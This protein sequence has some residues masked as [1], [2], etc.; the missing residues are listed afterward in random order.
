MADFEQ[1][2]KEIVDYLAPRQTVYEHAIYH[3]LFRRSH[4]EGSGEVRVGQRSLLRMLPRPSKEG[5]SNRGG[6]V[7]GGSQAHIRRTLQS[8]AGKGHIQIGDTTLEGTLIRV[9]LPHE[10]PECIAEIAAEQARQQSRLLGED[11]YNVPE[12]RLQVLARDGYKCRYC[13]KPVT[14]KDATLDHIQPVSAGGPHSFDNLVT[15]CLM[16]N[17]IKSARRPEDSLLDILDRFK[18]VAAHESTQ[19]GA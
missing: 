12:N 4:L 7:S 2:Y 8:L 13:N 15:C 11:F 5:T 19:A 14:R 9:K 17:S 3:L 6:I 1:L 18:K 10:I 16:C